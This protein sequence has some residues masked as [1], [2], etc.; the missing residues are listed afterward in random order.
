MGLAAVAVVLSTMHYEG[1]VAATGG[2]YVDVPITVPAGTVEIQI[3]HSDGSEFDILDWGVW[4]PEGFRGWG[5]GNTENAI[6]GVNESS[7]SYLPG[8]ITPGT[9]T[10]SIGKAKL[11]ADG[12]HYSIDVVCRDNATLTV[13][14]RAPYSPVVLNSERRW[15]KGDFHVHSVN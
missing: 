4:S 15:Y 7:R 2:D 6:I 5:G 9:W 10:V 11:D 1:D 3:T 8:P 14:P 12:G 13:Q